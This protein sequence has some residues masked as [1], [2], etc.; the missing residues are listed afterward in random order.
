MS[1]YRPRY[2]RYQGE[3][4]PTSIRYQAIAKAELSRLMSDKWFRRLVL[5]SGAPTLILGVY[6]YLAAIL[7]QGFGWNPLGGDV[8]T[9]LY[10][11]QPWFILLMF[12]G[13]GAGL[14]SRDLKTRAFTL[15]FT[16]PV[17]VLQYVA[18]KVLALVA[19]A[20][21]V[22]LI[23]GLLLALAQFGMHS[24]FGLWKLLDTVW[25][26]ALSSGL[27]AVFMS[28]LILLLSAT[29]GVSSRV[30]GMVWLVAFICLIM[31]KELLAV[32]MGLGALGSVVSPYDVMLGMT[33]VCFKGDFNALPSLVAIVVYSVFF[34][35]ALY[36]R[37]QS[38]E[39]AYT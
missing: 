13:F 21:F 38:F 12:T 4:R 25:R 34:L 10:A 32:Q 3:L 33:E 36:T 35:V 22:T 2:T 20:L 19:C 15:I 28:S 31:L 11:W 9:R 30:A 37:I 16:R 17:T 27:I 26:V 5:M 6:I 29:M 23:P 14:I 8:F 7:E 39:R 18:G 1:I 24:S